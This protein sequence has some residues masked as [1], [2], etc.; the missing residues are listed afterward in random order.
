M[1]ITLASSFLYLYIIGVGDYSQRTSFEFEQK[2]KK[3]TTFSIRSR[4]LVY[5]IHNIIR[6]R[7]FLE[8]WPITG[9]LTFRLNCAA[10]P[11]R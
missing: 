2:K 7:R 6:N 4:P 1:I 9:N 8:K 3:N 5:N 11:A 10:R